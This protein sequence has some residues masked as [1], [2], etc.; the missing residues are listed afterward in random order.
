MPCSPACLLAELFAALVLAQD[1]P[2]AP[3][4][5]PLPTPA[6]IPTPPQQEP[7]PSTPATPPANASQQPTPVPAGERPR[8][9]DGKTLLACFARMPGLEATYTEEKK[10]ALLALPLKSKGRILFLPPGHLFR[11]VEAPEPATLRITPDELRTEDR[12]GKQSIDLRR[13]DNLRVF[14]TALVQVFA[15]D[16]AALQKAFTVTYAPVADSKNGWTLELLPKEQSLQ[17]M[18]KSLQLRGVGET[19]TAILVVDPNGDRTTTTIVTAD[20]ARTFDAAEKKRWF[21]I[22]AK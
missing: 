13:S 8:P 10:L 9:A 2:P 14:I 7:R 18:M 20:V 5:V 3:A 1:P 6:P 12:D 19:V 21:G 22:E 16:E 4:P 17:R 15:G 11:A